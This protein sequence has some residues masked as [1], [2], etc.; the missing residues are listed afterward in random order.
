MSRTPGRRAALA[1]TGG[2][3]VALLGLSACGGSGFDDGAATGGGSGD[4]TGDGELSI[5]IG[6]SGPAETEAVEAAVAAWSEESGTAATVTVAQDLPQ[7]LAQGFA[8]GSPPDLFYVS[9][10]LFQTYAQQ[11]SLLAYG[12]DLEAADDFYPALVQSFTYEDQLYCAPK[13]FSTLA[14]EVDNGAWAEAGLT[15]ADVPTTWDELAAVAQ[16]LQTPDRAGLTFAPEYARAGAFMAAAGGGLTNAD[17]TE[18][19]ADSPENVEALT[20]LQGL[21][22]DGSLR[23]PADIGAGWGGEALATGAAA[24][25]VEGNWISGIRTDYPDLDYSV[26]PLP[27]GPAGPATLTFTT[28]WGVSA[29]T[30]DADA[31]VDLVDHLVSAEQQLAFAEAF[32]PMPSVQS[33]ADAWREA[34]PDQAAFLD[35]AD[36]AQPVLNLPGSS[37]VVA[38]LN[39]QLEGLASGDP[40][41]ILASV[42]G[43]L[44]PV[45]EAAGS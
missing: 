4:A 1:L 12:D 20:Y 42:Q 16:Q 29:T 7:Q 10:D 2:S 31:A 22:E 36:V 34:Y 17:Q 45:V 11:G 41:G 3:L 30:G 40:A 35:G 13:D 15:D 6:S 33:A 24:M 5:L 32:G 38:D 44:E 9:A 37:D 8:A 39:A 14:L 18:A 27:A 19:T 26:F 28:C 43:N 25:T 21:L 23:Y